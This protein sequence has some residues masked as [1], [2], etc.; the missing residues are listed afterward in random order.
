MTEILAVITTYLAASL[1]M[2]TPLTLAGLGESCSEK[3][4]V[5]NIGLEAIMLSGSFCGFIVTF[6]T[7]NLFLG[8]LAG[9]AG[10]I[11]VSMLHAVLSIKCC[12]DQNMI[13]LALNFLFL[14]LTSF[15]F[16]KAFGQTTVLPTCDTVNVIRIPLL[17]E[18]P[19]LGPVLFTQ[20][21]FVYI[22]FIAIGVFWFVFYKTDWGIQLTAVGEHPRAADTAGLNVFG[23]RYGACLI[24]GIFGGMAGAYIT[25]SQL[26]FFMENVTAGKGYMALVAVILGRRNP[27]GVLLAAMLIGFADALQFNLQTMG[28]A[29][30]SQAFSM[31][32][33]VAAVIVLLFSVNHSSNPSALGIP[34]QRNKR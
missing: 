16:L 23:I 24:N 15:L 3:S 29:V 12:A 30:P 20:N 33:Y 2:A 7:S 21:I 31:M 18:I 32:P 10:G 34:Y 5:I 11:L 28:I 13:G 17:S 1:R 4:G 9:I 26:G 27:I 6:W 19:V 25:L 14:G 22:M 8:I